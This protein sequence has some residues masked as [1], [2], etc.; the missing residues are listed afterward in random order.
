MEDINDLP[1]LP[2]FPDGHDDTWSHHHQSG[3]DLIFPKIY[4]TWV[5]LANKVI[6]NILVPGGHS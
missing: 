4:D 6:K 5:F 2:D 1:D 3:F